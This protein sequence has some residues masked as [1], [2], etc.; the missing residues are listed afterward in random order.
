MNNTENLMTGIVDGIKASH[1]IYTSSSEETDIVLREVV[2]KLLGENPGRDRYLSLVA[3]LKLLIHSGERV[4]R[5][6]R[7]VH[8]TLSDTLS[9]E[10]RANALNT[11]RYERFEKRED[12]TIIYNLRRMMRQVSKEMR[13]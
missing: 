2:V 1:N 9:E 13:A 7:D 4:I 3:D 5:T 8:K 10:A 12:M 11:A 6:L